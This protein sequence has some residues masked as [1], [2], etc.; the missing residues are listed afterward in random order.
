MSDMYRP[1]D[2]GMATTDHLLEELERRALAGPGKWTGNQCR[3]V[4][5]LAEKL[6]QEPINR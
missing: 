1:L 6:N 4:K 3:R 5:E 2:L